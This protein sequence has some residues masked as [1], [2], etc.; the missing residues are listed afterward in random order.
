MHIM[1]IT[2]VHVIFVLHTYIHFDKYILERR[3]R[4][5]HSN[6]SNS[7]KLSNVNQIKK[8]LLRIVFIKIRK[9]NEKYFLDFQFIIDVNEDWRDIV[10]KEIISVIRGRG[11]ISFSCSVNVGCIALNSSLK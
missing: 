2:N 5:I 10:I 9:K 1:T 6:K 4:H 11:A 7:I 3:E 8:H